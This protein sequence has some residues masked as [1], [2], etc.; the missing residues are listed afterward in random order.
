MLVHFAVL[1]VMTDF[2][3]RSLLLECTHWYIISAHFGMPLFV[4]FPVV[5]HVSLVLDKAI[6]V[7]L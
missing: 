4:Q 2:L 3:G 6:S 1:Y 7:A 5:L